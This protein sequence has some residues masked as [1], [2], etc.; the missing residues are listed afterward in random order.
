MAHWQ[1]VGFVHGVMNTDNMS[2]LGLTID[3]GPY[4]WVDDFDPSWT[5]NTTDAQQR[6]YRFGAQ[7]QVGMWNVERLGVAL[8]PLL[9]DEGAIEAALHAYQRAFEGE[10]SRRF[11]A[12]LGLSVSDEAVEHSHA[13]FAWLAAGETDMTLFFRGLCAVA[14]GPEPTTF[15]EPL[16]EAFYD[17]PPEGYLARGLE[18]L[19]RW[20]KLTR[21]EDASPERLALRMRAVNPKY[22]LRNYLAQEAIDLAHGG[23][24]SGIH[25]L[26]D[27]LRRPFDEQPGREH[28]AQKRPDWARSKPGCSALSCSS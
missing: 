2:I 8:L 22:V 4:G 27:V 21:E 15:P 3:Y 25:A 24:A 12:K 11:C 18:W 10:A 17:A 1:A 16:K 23:D 28:F 9:G 7:P 5:P 20:W 6:R 13:L 19:Q 26:L 14:E